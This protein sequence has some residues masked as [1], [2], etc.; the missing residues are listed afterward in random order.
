MA[1]L[2]GCA[3]G[4]V[5]GEAPSTA[6]GP[7][8]AHAWDVTVAPPA[9]DAPDTITLPGNHL[10]TATSPSFCTGPAYVVELDNA[11]DYVVRT[12]QVLTAPVMIYGGRNVRIIGIQIDLSTSSCDVAPVPPGAS[13]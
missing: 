8:P 6:G 13:G 5:G 2:L 11:R 7:P 10:G 12:T 1:A 9:L 3:N 4:V